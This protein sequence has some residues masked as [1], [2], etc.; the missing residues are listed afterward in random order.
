MKVGIA[1][2]GFMGEV[3]AECYAKLN[4][5]QLWGV[6]EKSQ[7]RMDKFVTK[8]APKKTYSDVF[9]MIA[10]EE[11]DVIDICLPSPMH[12]AVAIEALKQNKHVLLEKPIALNLDD[13]LKIKQAAE[14]SRGKFMVAHVLRFWPQYTVIRKSLQDQL[15]G[16]QIQEIYASRFNE[17][18]LWSEGTWIMEEKQSGGL[19]IDLMIHDIDF[20]MWNLGKVNRVWCKGIYNEND[21]AIQ[22][23]AVLEMKS[24][25]VCYIE[26]GYL[27]PSGSGLSSQMRIYGS[28]GLLEMYSHQDKI[29]L[30]ET[31]GG[32]KELNVP[33][34]DGYFEE[35]AYFV[36][37]IRQG[38]E[39]EVVTAQDAIE[40]LKVCLG[41]RDSLKRGT[42]I[43]ID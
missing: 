41:L 14:V 12:P 36:D 19:V 3:H 23:M 43:A 35:I 16:Q 9:D 30:V 18:P 25:A 20:V 40:S 2:A 31:G 6:A 21:F 5:V 29:K 33:S 27:N 34:M 15:L 8:F 13:A 28:D 42:W 39:P 11:I 38:R 17:L 7:E 32:Q 26:G 4:G 1:G 37:C 22:V 10:D 24:G